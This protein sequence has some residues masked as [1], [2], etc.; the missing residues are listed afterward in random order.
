MIKAM[1]LSFLAGC[2]LPPD[3]LDVSEL[4]DPVI[5]GAQSG[6]FCTGHP[7]CN[8]MTCLAMSSPA[9]SQEICI[10]YDNCGSRCLSDSYTAQCPELTPG[11]EQGC[12]NYCTAVSSGS[13]FVFCDA[14]CISN[15]LHTCVTGEL[16]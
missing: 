15:V 12:I 13:A 2:V 16:E 3:Q 10:S 7:R 4:A 8:P 11:E 14:A 9:G 5:G 1:L 6:A